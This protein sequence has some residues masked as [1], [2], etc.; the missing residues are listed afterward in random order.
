MYTKL[1]QI[2]TNNPKA[3]PKL[4]LQNKFKQDIAFSLNRKNNDIWITNNK[5]ASNGKLVYGLIKKGEIE[6]GYCKAAKDKNI[7]AGIKYILNLYLND[8]AL[9]AK[10]YG[11]AEHKCMYCNHPLTASESILHGYGPIC[12]SNYSLPWGDSIKAAKK[13]IKTSIAIKDKK[14]S[15]NSN[16]VQLELN[17]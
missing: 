2:L 4:V 13:A 1:L 9:Y 10:K 3:W 17:L 8:P 14:L 6:I 15:F 16:M 11:D 7:Q 5:P 12:A